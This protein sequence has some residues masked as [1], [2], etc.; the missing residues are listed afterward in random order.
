VT[1]GH[2]LVA[3]ATAALWCAAGAPVV[4]QGQ[5]ATTRPDQ[6]PMRVAEVER[7]WDTYVAAQATTALNLTDEQFLRFATRLQNLQ[8]LRR[9]VQRQRR[10]LTAELNAMVSGDGPVDRAA[11]TARLLQ[12]DEL[13][14][15][16]AQQ[17]RRAYA[18]IDAV[19]NLRQRVRFRTFEERMAQRKL[20]LLAEARRAARGGGTP[21]REPPPAL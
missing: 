8:N 7:M 6:P 18:R 5:G 1:L 14:V 2:N 4:A 9:R 20:E 19:L 3:L 10:A 11:V 13:G 17:V 15:Q 16:S 12:L 21:R